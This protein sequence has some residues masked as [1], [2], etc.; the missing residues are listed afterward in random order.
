M[1][2][3]KRFTLIELLVV[4][5][6]IAILAAMLLP[7][8]GEARTKAK[9]TACMS[10][11]H[12]LGIALQNYVN[13]SDER[14][15]WVSSSANPST[16]Q[17]S[18]FKGDCNAW[19]NG[20]PNADLSGFGCLWAAGTVG[21]PNILYCPDYRAIT[22]W[23]VPG[24]VR[25]NNIKNF[26]QSVASRTDTSCD[27]HLSWLGGSPTLRQFESVV[28][29]GAGMQV[30]NFGRNMHDNAGRRLPGIYWIADGYGVFCYYYTGISHRDGL[31][32]NL[33]RLDGGV[34]TVRSWQTR[35]PHMMDYDYY[36]PYN[37]RPDWGFWRYFGGRDVT[38]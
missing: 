8:L 1:K 14:M 3:W 2:R 27:Y 18:P 9:Q 25:Q 29:L 10:Q 32:M 6:I 37:D 26:K 15:P 22:G 4:I 31:Y 35:Q 16:C 5:S 36:F 19:V 28:G 11:L 34:D 7:A 17:T 20:V 38:L 24:V 13:D 33:G 30:S 12:Q 21:D 23:G